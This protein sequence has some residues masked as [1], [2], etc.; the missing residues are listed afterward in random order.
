M[1]RT[2]EER[3]DSCD[4][5]GKRE[6]AEESLERRTLHDF[7]Y[8]G[9][10]LHVY[11]GGRGGKQHIPMGKVMKDY[12]KLVTSM[13]ASKCFNMAGLQLS[14]IIINDPE[15]RQKFKDGDKLVGFL[16]PLSIAAMQA[17]YEEGEE[18]LTQMD[19]YVDEN[20]RYVKSFIDENLPE[21]KFEIPDA[22][23]LAWVKRRRSD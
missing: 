10:F 16:N 7:G 23:Y 3:M 13:S 12:P 9:H 11:E 4:T 20:F 17:A 1:D 19:L 5:Q 6:P 22:T 2:K 8:F 14:N 15:I 21:I 18:W